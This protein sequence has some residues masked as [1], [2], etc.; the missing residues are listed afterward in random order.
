MLSFIEAWRKTLYERVIDIQ[1]SRKSLVYDLL[2]TVSNEKMLSSGRYGIIYIF[3]STRCIAMSLAGWSNFNYTGVSQRI[4]C[5]FN[6]LHNAN[7]F[8]NVCFYDSLSTSRIH[9]WIW[10]SWIWEV[11]CVCIYMMIFAAGSN[12]QLYYGIFMEH[13]NKGL[14]DQT[15]PQ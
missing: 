4:K 11:V 8:D 13:A 14:L 12:I 6:S 15:M 3:L 1:T 9:Y 10:N 2:T 7:C 5:L